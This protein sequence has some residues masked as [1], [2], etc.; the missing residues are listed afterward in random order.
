M[1]HGH[2]SDVS[3]CSLS[4]QFFDVGDPSCTVTEELLR[5]GAGEGKIPPKL[6]L[7]LPQAQETL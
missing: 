4:G 2:H 1:M 3:V 7:G 6:R 5:I